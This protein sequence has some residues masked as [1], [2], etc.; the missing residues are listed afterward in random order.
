MV[1]INEVIALDFTDGSR[2][3]DQLMALLDSTE[4]PTWDDTGAII[5]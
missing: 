2:R 1:N 3:A 5:D 4:R